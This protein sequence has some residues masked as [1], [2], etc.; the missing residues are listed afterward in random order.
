M[1]LRVYHCKLSFGGGESQNKNVRIWRKCC[2]I[3]FRPQEFVTMETLLFSSRMTQILR[4]EH[5]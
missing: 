2:H 3:F 4:V 5:M 1:Y